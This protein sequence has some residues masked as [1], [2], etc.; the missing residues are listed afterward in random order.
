MERCPHIILNSHC[1][2]GV[3]KVAFTLRSFKQ[4][5][6][7]ISIF[8]VEQ[9]L[10]QK[11]FQTWTGHGDF[12]IIDKIRNLMY[13][14]HHTNLMKPF[15]QAGVVAELNDLKLN[16]V[17]NLGATG[18]TPTSKRFPTHNYKNRTLDEESSK[19]VFLQKLRWIGTL[20]LCPPLPGRHKTGIM[21]IYLY[22][23]YV[24]GGGWKPLS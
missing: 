9:Q 2:A 12:S 23:R 15:L 8:V 7:V 24:W 19:R 17:K 22:P 1:I 10:P 20:F 13:V 11:A 14:Q 18:N 4:E 21:E 3:R 5:K 16:W 6:S